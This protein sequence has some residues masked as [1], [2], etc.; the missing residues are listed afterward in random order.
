[1][2]INHSDKLYNAGHPY[3]S[4]VNFYL[5]WNKWIVILITFSVT[6]NLSMKFN[7]S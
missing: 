7:E 6:R 4:S 5:V 3:Y 1:M 2:I